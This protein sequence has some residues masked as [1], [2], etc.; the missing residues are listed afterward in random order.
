L[1]T[2]H[3]GQ[4]DKGLD[5]WQVT[6]P[7]QAAQADATRGSLLTYGPGGAVS[8]RVTVGG[9]HRLRFRFAFRKAAGGP[10][11][12]VVH[13]YRGD[14][15]LPGF[16]QIWQ[17][18]PT[19]ADLS[20]ME[21]GFTTA[22]ETEAITLA[23]S[24]P[25]TTLAGLSIVDLGVSPEIKPDGKELLPD[26]GWESY[27]P[28]STVGAESSYFQGPGWMGWG[29]DA[30][31]T[32]TSAP[33]RVHSG[34]QALMVTTGGGSAATAG[35][36]W[37]PGFPVTPDAW[38]DFSAWVKG[39]GLA[40]LWLLTGGDYGDSF[41]TSGGEFL[42]S[43]DEWRQI[44][45]LVRADNPAHKYLNPGVF[46]KG[47]VFFDD[48]SF[49][50]VSSAEA[51]AIRATMAQYPPPPGRVT[52]TAPA[53]ETRSADP[54]TLENPFVKAVLSPVGGGRVIELTDKQSGATWKGN[55]LAL[56]FPDQPVPIDWSAPF[57]TEVA[58]EG[59]QV[60]FSHTVTGGPAAPFLD[61]VKIEQIFTLGKSDRAVHVTWRL[62]NT[63]AGPRLPNPAVS[64]VCAADAGVRRL[65]TYG[66]NGLLTADTAPAS[67]RNLAAGWMA[68]STEKSSLVCVFDVTAAQDGALDPRSRSLAWNYLRLT[69]PPGGSWETSAWLAA[70]SL[71]EVEYA[72]RQSAVQAALGKAG[73]RYTLTLAD[74]PVTGADSPRVRAQV[75]DYGGVK[76][77]EGTAAQPVVFPE[78]SGRFITDLILQP[79]KLPY[80][81]ELFNDPRGNT[82]GIQGASE[83][84]YRPTVP[85]RVL[86]LPDLGDLSGQIAAGNRVLWA[87][88][89]WFQD[90]PLDA[91][92]KQAGL[93]V[94]SLD[95]AAGF[96][97][98]AEELAA[99]RAIVLCN[100]G[101]THLTAPARA[102]LSQYV[103]GG[104]RLLV[105][106]G[107][108][109][110]GNALSTGTDLED[111]LPVKLGGPFET[112]ALAGEAQL[113]HP[114]RGS[115]LGALPWTDN[116]RVYWRHRVT[117]RE[118]ATPLALAG[119]E[120]VLVEGVFG[121]GK[122][123]LYCGTVEGDPQPGEVAVWAW[124]GWPGLWE[125]TIARLLGK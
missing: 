72:D 58:A 5:G 63:A 40:S 78:P 14:Q 68:A 17:Q 93:T 71:G 8:P 48:L 67:T 43:P 70:V 117:L 119:A 56:T 116:P 90:Y 88:G 41:A 74:A 7:V 125:L 47:R 123:I 33:S 45:Y 75:V 110:L 26:G 9:N 94:E 86:R 25:A 100:V 52:Q 99:F 98:E 89:I 34:K 12:C 10:L 11:Y 109:S 124:K 54:V 36:R 82:P 121:R 66:E 1:Y 13:Q 114:V 65:A 6:G 122:V 27:V 73:D 106:G 96:P 21:L 69:L 24:G 77:A 92:L 60:T 49:K 30:S 59:T 97:E 42:V 2:A 35:F 113:L 112:Y 115:G 104:G 39:A 50:Q 103:R 31:K 62:T 46:V 118:G 80:T 51:A 111:L 84:Q 18:N 22:P 108:L 3:W 101:A 105:L 79:G 37:L 81:V 16:N 91:P 32:I 38:Y 83:M 28:R 57:R 107:S 19:I 61:G 55:L 102:A 15:E 44:H 76:L 85:A 95:V 53:G 23:L 4:G 64:T 29:A 20:P 87:K 120:P